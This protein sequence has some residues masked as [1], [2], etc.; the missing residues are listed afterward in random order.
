MPE[1]HF[2]SVFKQNMGI[3]MIALHVYVRT[4]ILM[5]I[6]TCRV[7]FSQ[8]VLVCEKYTRIVTATKPA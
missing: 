4:Y 5:Y 2:R 6:Y 3:H 8:H 7:Q 1:V